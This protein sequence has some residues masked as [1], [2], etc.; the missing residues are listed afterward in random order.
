MPSLFEIGSDLQALDDLL[1]EN[2]GDITDPAV[3]AAVSEWF[4]KASEDEA[5]KLEAYVGLIR[6]LSAEVATAKA[7]A[8]LFRGKAKAREGRIDFLKRRLREHLER[9]GRTKATTA[10]GRTLSIQSNGGAV[11]VR[12][13]FAIDLADVPERFVKVT[14]AIDVDAVRKAL[15]IGEVLPFASLGERETHLRIK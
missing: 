2:G 14:K 9:T 13:A 3:E 12:L 6:Q 10:A 8:D 1:D 11:P 5:E 15:E 4:A 7:E